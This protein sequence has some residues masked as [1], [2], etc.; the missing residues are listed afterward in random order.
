MASEQ[1]T[2]TIRTLN[3]VVEKS[4]SG[5]RSSLARKYFQELIRAVYIYHKIKKEPHGNIRTTNLIISENGSLVIDKSTNQGCKES[6]NLDLVR[7][8]APK[9]FK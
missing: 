7:Y 8:L 9:A 3:E 6:E 4:V 1:S 5:L 2:K